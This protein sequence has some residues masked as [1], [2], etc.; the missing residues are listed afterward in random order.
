MSQLNVCEAEAR[1]K[2]VSNHNAKEFILAIIS[3]HWKSS[4]CQH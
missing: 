1:K 3:Q 2:D 4:A